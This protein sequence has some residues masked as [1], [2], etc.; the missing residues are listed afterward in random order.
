[1]RYKISVRKIGRDNVLDFP[2]RRGP[3]LK[4]NVAYIKDCVLR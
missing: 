2:K 1:M 3:H 4:Y